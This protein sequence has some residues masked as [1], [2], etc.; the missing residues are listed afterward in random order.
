MSTKS[1]QPQ[2]QRQPQ[3]RSADRRTQRTKKLLRQALIELA[4]QGQ[5]LGN[6]TV[7]DL[8]AQ[9]EINRG[10]FYLHYHDVYDLIEQ[11]QSEMLQGLEAIAS[12]MNIPELLRCAQQ[13]E[14]YPGLVSVFEFWN[15][16]ADFCGLMFGPKGDPSFA[17]RVKQLMTERMYGKIL[18]SLPQLAPAEPASIPIDFIF[19][20]MTSANIGFIQHW[21]ETG[22]RQQPKEIARMMTMMIG[23]GPIHAFID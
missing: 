8:T 16:H 2:S 22:R 6:I 15:R 20:Y 11:L 23:Q 14:P 12:Q 7:S 9:A 18:E 5:G 10:T 4:Q 3:P 1:E 21:F 13:R 19:A 17:R